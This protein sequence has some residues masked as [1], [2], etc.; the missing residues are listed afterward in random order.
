MVSLF[1]NKKNIFI[2]DVIPSVATL[3]IIL[4]WAGLADEFHGLRIGAGNRSTVDQVLI[5]K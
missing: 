2:A 1:G 5:G 3:G 4:H